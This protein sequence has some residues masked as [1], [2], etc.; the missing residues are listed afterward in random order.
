VLGA[1]KD[2]LKCNL[3][4]RLK[5]SEMM[6]EGEILKKNEQIDDFIEDLDT[7]AGGDNTYVGYTDTEIV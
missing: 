1:H 6:D 3:Q 2:V 5:I 4:K 7:E